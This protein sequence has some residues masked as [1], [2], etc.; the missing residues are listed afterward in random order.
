MNEQ[1]WTQ[2][3]HSPAT[4]VYYDALRGMRLEAS[5]AMMNWL[6]TA[7]DKVGD[8]CA[9]ALKNA[10]SLKSQADLIERILELT[11]KDVQEA[12]EYGK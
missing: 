11:S 4:K 10:K 3:K 1:D 12:L 2:W 7:S 5:D 8:E 6:A 9:M